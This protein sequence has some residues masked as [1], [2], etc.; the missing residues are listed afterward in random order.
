MLDRNRTPKLKA[1]S[2]NH[3]YSFVDHRFAIPLKIGLLGTAL[4]FNIVL[5]ELSL[6]HNRIHLRDL[7][8]FMLGVRESVLET[9]NLE[10]CE[11]SDDGAQVVLSNIPQSLKELDLSRNPFNSDSCQDM[12][13]HTAKNHQK[14]AFLH[15]DREL[16]C[17]QEVDYNTRLNL[18]GRRILR[19]SS[20]V[21][22]SL[23]AFILERING[24]DWKSYDPEGL[25]LCEDALLYTLKGPALC[26]RQRQHSPCI[27]SQPF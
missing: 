6:S 21:P 19:S 2:L 1:L 3:Q 16:N 26:G 15:I 24:I 10:C 12:L 20:A 13:L 14:I 18:A 5:K 8:I 7:E 11:L 9:L 23:W 17:W 4:K 25:G 27:D 22:L